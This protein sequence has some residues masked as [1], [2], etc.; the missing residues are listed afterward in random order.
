MSL[1]KS[2]KS[3]KQINMSLNK[4]NKSLNQINKSLNQSNNQN[5]Y[6][7]EFLAIC[8]GKTSSYMESVIA[9][10]QRM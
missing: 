7:K 5:T 8:T 1:N 4:S 3:P 2:N 10:L 6:G 9:Q